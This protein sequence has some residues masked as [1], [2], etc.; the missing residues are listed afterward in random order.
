MYGCR[1]A[2]EDHTGRMK[3]RS[4]LLVE[5][6]AELRTLVRRALERAD[7]EVDEAST[8]AQALSAVA[9][10]RHDA[11]LLDIGLPDSDG[12]DLCQA[13]RARGVNAPVLFLTA[14][15]A[16]ADRIAG[17]S[18]GGD[19]YVVK[20]FDLGELVARVGALLRRAAPA[21][22]VA[23]GALRLDPV[24]HA[25]SA[26]DQEVPLTPTEFHLL[27]CLAAQPGAVIRR[28][29]LAAAAW[30]HEGI[31]HDNTLDVHIARIRRKLRDLHNV[32]Q[33]TTVHG[34][35]YSLR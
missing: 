23:V 34:L 4:V 24:S 7:L 29:E 16:V 26:G 22:P 20:P 12:R 30:P 6:D 17:F 27:A 15:E 18:A 11:L 2:D 33:V 14:R 8:G 25:M 32:P 28:Q 13:L 19:D 10:R 21:A 35:G 31:V 3:A 5:D 9:R 1:N